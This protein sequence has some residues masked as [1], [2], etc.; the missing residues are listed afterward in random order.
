MKIKWIDNPQ[1]R[2]AALLAA[3]FLGLAHLFIKLVLPWYPMAYLAVMACAFFAVVY[4][5]LSM[6]IEADRTWGYLVVQI[7]AAAAGAFIMN[8][9]MFEYSRIVPMAFVYTASIA[10]VLQLVAFAVSGRLKWFCALWL[11]IAWIYGI[12]TVQVFAFTGNMI[13]LSQILSIRTGL[14]VLR[15]YKPSFAPFMLSST[16]LYVLSMIALLRV[17]QSV[18][19]GLSCRL[20]TLVVAAVVAVLPVN[21]WRTMKPTTFEDNCMRVYG[22][23][24]ELLLELKNFRVSPPEAYTLDEAAALALRYA[25]VKK[26]ETR[27]PHIIAVMFEAFSDLSVL[28]AFDTDVDPLAFTRS[29]WNESIHGYYLASTLAGGT[30]RSEWEFLTGNSMY[31]LPDAAIPFRQYMSDSIHSV[32]GLLENE[33]YHTIG[34]H[35]FDG[36]GWDRNR[37]YPAMGFDEIYFEDDLEW[38]SRVR[39]YVSDSA[40][41]H[42]VIRLFESKP[43]DAP[44]FLFGVTMQNHGGYA[45]EGFDPIVHIEGLDIDCSEEEQYLSLVKL[46]DD[47]IQELIDYFRGVDEDVEIIFFGDHQPG[48]TLGF[49]N[50]IHLKNAGMKYIVPYVIWKNHDD[51]EEETDMTSANLLPVRMLREAGVSLPPYYQFLEHFGETVPAI[52]ARGYQYGGSI[53]LKGDVPDETSGALLRDYDIFQYANVFDKEADDEWFEGAFAADQ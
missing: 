33:G 7:A 43:E 14:N 3:A 21:A 4:L 19:T 50:G 20:F 42:Q 46:T 9:P 27:K 35:P 25:P 29:L 13:T 52:C 53:H 17:H 45:V 48:L 12:V 10:L 11:T 18:P 28:G 22:I 51:T 24:M 38:D 8:M 16:L 44:M 26:T 2:I 40:F 23:P 31:F 6:Q 39:G 41:V 36:S 47:A 49:Y 15:S 5:T 32:V 1:R 34:M 30:S 37:V